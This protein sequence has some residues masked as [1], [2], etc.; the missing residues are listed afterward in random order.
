[1]FAQNIR[2]RKHKTKNFPSDHDIIALKTLVS[3]TYTTLREF[4]ALLCK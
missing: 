2:L 3:F 1:M 4:T